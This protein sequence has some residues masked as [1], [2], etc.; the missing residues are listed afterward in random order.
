MPINIRNLAIV[1]CAALLAA[2][3]AAN[4][5][6]A[7]KI[8]SNNSRKTAAMQTFAADTHSYSNPRA[9]RVRHVDL[10]WNVLFDQKILQGTATLTIE[11]AANGGKE[12]LILDT[13]DLKIA[14]VETSV[15]GARFAPAKFSVGA[16]DKILGAPLTVELPAKANLVRIHYS[17]SPSASGLQ[18]LEPSQ[19]LAKKRLLCSRRRR[20]FTPARLYRYRI[21]RRCA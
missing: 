3:F 20:R 15:D 6:E 2:A 7:Q 18:W 1:F 13:R 11:R 16:A 8:S 21:R 17:T 5:C 19:R 12:P 14:K 4:V 10:D 9:V